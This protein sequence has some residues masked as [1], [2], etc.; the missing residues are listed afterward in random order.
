MRMRSVAPVLIGALALGVLAAPAASA[1]TAAGNPA[2]KITKA[3]V[4]SLVLGPKT[5]KTW[6][7]SVTVTDESGIKGV[8]LMPWPAMVPDFAPKA[9]DVADEG[10]AA[11][12]KATSATTSVCTYKESINSH[13]DLG[14]NLGAG[15]W[16]VAVQVTAKDGGTTFAP[17]AT[18]FTFKR[19]ASLTAK[20]SAKS[21]KKNST[22]TVT[23]QLKA[24]D[25]KS[26][27]VVNYG[28]QSVT[29]QFRKSG[30]TAWKAVKTVKADAK[31]AVK[32][33][34]KVSAAGSWRY[35]FAGN[36]SVA[37]VNSAGATVSLKK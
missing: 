27:K 15:R 32:A 37:A 33:T 8:K 1:A 5:T 24:A 20:A 19:Q 3:V 7:A 11:T 23:G 26:G 17:K 10:A 9:S 36:G 31:G 25:W 22:V 4:S 6:T 35:A 34:A 16:Y 18:S 14:D 30:T 2:P 28:K 29:L 12:C 21:V 13:A